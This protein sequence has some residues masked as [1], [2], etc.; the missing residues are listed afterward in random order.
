MQIGAQPSDIYAMDET[1]VWFDMLSDTSVDER[2]AKNVSVK[3]TG[4]E[5]SRCTVVLTANG[6]GRKLKPHVVLFGGR[7]SQGERIECE[8]VHEWNHY[9]KFSEWV[10]E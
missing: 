2:G 6:S 5:K 7:K 9:I 3:T 10:D 8:Q 1:A 4:H